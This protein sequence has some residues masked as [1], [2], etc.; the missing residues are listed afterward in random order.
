VE[1]YVDSLRQKRIDVLGEIETLRQRVVE[2]SSRL[3]VKENQLRNIDDLLRLETP[4]DATASPSNGIG[5][6]VRAKIRD[7]AYEALKE[8]GVP[9]HYR[10]LATRLAQ[11]DVYI[12][13]QDPAANLIAHLSRDA[14]FLR[15]EGRGM[16]GLVEWPRKVAK[17]AK[18]RRPRATLSDR[19]SSKS[20]P[21]ARTA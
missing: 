5:V 16:Y 9:L 4:S 18:P 10:E 7:R 21:K 2:L 6:P 13:G 17:P 19:R 1:S 12:P 20:I 15:T 3:T 11:S 14:R 8:R